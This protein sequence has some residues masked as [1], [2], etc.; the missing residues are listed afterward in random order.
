MIYVDAFTGVPRQV[1]V[2]VV[3]LVLHCTTAKLPEPPFWAAIDNGAFAQ[4]PS[5]KVI[6]RVGLAEGVVPAVTVNIKAWS[7]PDAA[8]TAAPVPQPAPST[9]AASAPLYAVPL[10]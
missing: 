2:L 5:L 7:V 1:N 6:T 4:A 8:D 10:L 9:I 3:V